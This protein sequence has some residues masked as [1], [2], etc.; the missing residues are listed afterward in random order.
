MKKRTLT[1][2]VSLL[3][4]PQSDPEASTYELIGKIEYLD[5]VINEVLRLNPP[6]FNMN[7]QCKK[8]CNINGVHIPEGMQIVIPFYAL[9]NDPNVWPDVDRFDPERFRSPAK[10]KRH[11]YQVHTVDIL[12]QQ[13]H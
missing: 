11:P 3:L 7:R 2:I 13:P 8:A 10:E 6:I 1:S 12:G 9:H 4:H 5:C